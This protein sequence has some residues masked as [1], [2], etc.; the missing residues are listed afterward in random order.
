MRLRPTDTGS[1]LIFGSSVDSGLNSLLTDIRDGRE[2]SLARA[3][4]MFDA[5][6]KSI[7]PTEIKFSKADFDESLGET[8]W[9]SLECKGH[10]ILEAY[11]EQVLP[12]I[13]R[14]ILVQHEVS[15]TN[16]LGDS[17][18]GVVDL[19]AQID[20][21]VYILD[22]K[23][24]SIKYSEDAAAISQ[25]LGTYFEALKYDYKLDGV[26]FIVIPK[27]IRKK[28]EPR[29][30]IE[31][32]LGNVDEKIMVETFAMYENVL[33]GIKSGEFRCTRQCCKN[34]WPCPYKGY[35]DSSGTDLTGLKYVDKKL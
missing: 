11:V 16:E 17:L 22:N 32:K 1:A 7:N 21:K 2:P 6:F 10:M 34:P 25:Q 24:S 26:G 35:C 33:D 18:I 23:T 12:K 19:V 5:Q 14:V 4:A 13:E 3:K 30:P 31:I 27:N 29:V 20:G 28:K 9:K 15:L 8:P